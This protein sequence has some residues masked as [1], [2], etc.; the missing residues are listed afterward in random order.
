MK[1]RSL[2]TKQKE[3]VDTIVTTGCSITE[4][5]QKV[6]YAKGESGRVVASKTLRLPHVQRY[7]MERIAN[8]I[9]LGAISASRKMVELSNGARSEY[10]QL[11]ASKDILDRAGIRMPD[12]VQHEIAGEVK[13]NIDLS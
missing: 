12:R 5:S 4:A 13:I 2:T 6:G 11:E 8:T 10:V 7:M 3:L 1:N 9:G